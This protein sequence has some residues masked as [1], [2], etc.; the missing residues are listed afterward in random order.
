MPMSKPS[1]HE[2]HFLLTRGMKHFE[3]RLHARLIAD[4]LRDFSAWRREL[5][6]VTGPVTL[7]TD[8]S[9]RSSES[10]RPSWPLERR[11]RENLTAREL[12]D[13]LML[14]VQDELNRLQCLVVRY[15]DFCQAMSRSLTEQDR[16]QLV[17]GYARDL[18]STGRGAR[19]DERARSRWFSER[20]VADRYRRQRGEAEQRLT[21]A[22]QCLGR[23]MQHV[24]GLIAKRN[25]AAFWDRM[26]LERL[27]ISA[28]TYDGDA[29]VHVAALDALRLPLQTVGPSVAS[30]LL[31]SSTRQLLRQIANDPTRDEWLQSAALTT[32]TVATKDRGLPALLARLAEPRPGDDLFVRRHSVQLLQ[33]LLQ[34]QQNWE[35]W[36]S[37]LVEDPSPFVRQ[38]VAATL[39]NA[40]PQLAEPGLRKLA[41]EDESAQVRAAA[42][43][44]SLRQA[45]PRALPPIVMTL[46]AE[47]L[48]REQHEFVLR[49]A[50]HV[51]VSW[52]ERVQ[53]PRTASQGSAASNASQRSA[54]SNEHGSSDEFLAQCYE[55][56]ILPP[57]RRLQAEAP[58]TPVRRWAAASA[59]KIWM[60]SH[61]A[62]SALHDRL[63][64]RSRR[65]QPGGHGRVPR[66][67]FRDLTPE[68]IGR[69]LAVLA[70][71]DFGYDLESSMWGYRLVKQPVFRFR[72]WR[73]GTSSFI[74]P[75]TSDK[76]FA[77]RSGVYPLRRFAL[78]PEFWPS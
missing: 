29:R 4:V 33:Q 54:T 45:P 78:P 60:R 53:D 27:L 41:L 36:P 25:C 1:S 39:W 44:E 59:E 19:R 77:T 66:K 64:A 69:T 31:S 15:S 26:R 52:Y 23:V 10:R 49:T 20:A 48:Q 6:T 55:E 75:P 30:G 42:L 18:G 16:Q 63:Q 38:Q 7:E 73:P 50:M 65:L 72:F 12:L 24:V 76:R 61:P 22:L 57:L 67:W 8:P 5:P 14:R 56:Q 34:E 74:P 51:A 28:L 11:R 43:V 17:F 37:Q 70:Q 47:V 2:A 71:D 62:A 58:S 32:L 35:A 46:L 9:D 3:Q 13:Y 21:F 40:P 68:Q